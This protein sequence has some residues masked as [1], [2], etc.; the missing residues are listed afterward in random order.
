MVAHFPS[1]LEHRQVFP[2]LANKS[3]FNFGGQG[4]LPQ[5]AL[6]A[7]LQTYQLWQERGPFSGQIGLIL[8]EKI[9]FLRELLGEEL[10]I[11]PT[12]LT[13]TENVT[14]GCNI[15]LWG[16]N[17][18]A[19]DR[20]LVTD[21]EHPGVVAII[22]EISRRFAVNIDICPIFETLNTGDPLTQIQSYLTPQT[23]L[24]VLSHILWNSGQL[25]PLEA[26][27]SLA[28][29]QGIPVLVDGAQSVGMLP[30]NLT[31]MGV[32]FYAFTGHKWLCGPAGVGGL[33]VRPDALEWLQPT[34]VGW[35]S[36]TVDKTGNIQGWQESGERFEVATS[37][38][39]EYEGLR[40]AI[41]TH[42]QWGTKTER[43][44]QICYLSAYL[45][46]KLQTIQGITC[47]K[48]SPP[49]SGLVSFQVKTGVSSVELVK[50][51]EKQGF[52]LRTLLNPDC[53]RACVHYFTLESEI[54]SLV[55]AIASRLGE[56]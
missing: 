9:S 46:E 25:L 32:D 49:L 14:A 43:Y 13:L 34:F 21:G 53:V 17:W 35:R 41:E 48:S 47:L 15:V 16:M 29:Q 19:G 37:A 24:L 4:P 1:T 45:W 7:I 44:A 31:E 6:E 10:G 56:M 33:Y 40:A 20:L 51:L 50:N 23:R 42:R 55:E 22:Q 2:A 36:I 38:Y 26:L 8:A 3:Y 27:V 54:D 39:P 52:F 30:L 5:P 18:Q 12:H 11:S 28:H